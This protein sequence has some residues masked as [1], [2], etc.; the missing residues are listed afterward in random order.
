MEISQIL[1]EMYYSNSN[2]PLDIIR[3]NPTK[4]IHENFNLITPLQNNN[5]RQNDIFL[6][7]LKIRKLNIDEN[8]F[9]N[10]NCCK[11]NC[12]SKFNIE[13]IKLLRNEIHASQSN[14]D[15]KQLIKRYIKKSNNDKN[16]FVLNNFNICEN[17][18]CK[19]LGISRNLIYYKQKGYIDKEHKIENL[20]TTFLKNLAS[21]E[22]FMPD[23]QHIH[24]SFQ[25]KKDVFQ[26]YSDMFP[27]DKT[28]LQYFTKIWNKNCNDIKVR[29]TNRFSYCS[30]CT[31]MDEQINELKD[32]I[33][34]QKLKKEKEIHI[35]DVFKDRDIYYE[36][37]NLSKLKPNIYLSLIIDGSDNMNYGLPYF[38]QK[39]KQS[40]KG[41]KFPIKLVGVKVHNLG[42]IV[43]TLPCNITSGPNSIINILHYTLDYIYNSYGNIFPNKSFPST[44]FLQVN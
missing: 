17:A 40:Q 4:Y 6:S 30:Y 21:Y 10:I 11:S 37:I 43:F 26:L 9:K 2:T 12:I 38:Y 1:S 7:P 32:S 16:L 5:K 28:S 8:E 14:L 35:L 18:F 3:N 44:L 33:L 31:E 27:N 20:I 23:K 42:D 34:I 13:Q 15:K 39:T 24:L 25:K 36:H 19:I 41:Y 22:N 29:K